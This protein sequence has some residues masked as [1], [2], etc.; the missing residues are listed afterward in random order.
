M[1]VGAGAAGCAA[2]STLLAHGF[3][4]RLVWIDQERQ[5]AYDRTSLSKFVIAGQMPPDE[6]PACG[7]GLSYWLQTF[8]PGEVV[9]KVLRGSGECAVIDWTFLGF[10]LPVWTLLAFS[11]LAAVAAWQVLRRD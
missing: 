3:A 5:P 9:M 1:V 7:P 4:G 6:V 11:G 2:V 8:S 10:A